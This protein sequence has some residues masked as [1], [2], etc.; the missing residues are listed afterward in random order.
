[1]AIHHVDH[2]TAERMQPDADLWPV[3][4]TETEIYLLP[5]GQVVIADLPVELADLVTE[6]GMTARVATSAPT[7][8]RPNEAS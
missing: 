2:A 7:P 3:L 6:L 5:D 1:V 8:P 4:P